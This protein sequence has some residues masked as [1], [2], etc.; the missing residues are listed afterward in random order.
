MVE[1]HFLKNL[2][3]FLKR[4]AGCERTDKAGEFQEEKR[5]PQSPEK[6]DW[7]DQFD[8]KIP[9]DEILRVHY[10]MVSLGVRPMALIGAIEAHP[11]KIQNLYSK[12]SCLAW[13]EG[14]GG[15]S[16][17]VRPIAFVIQEEEGVWARYGYAASGWIPETF[18]WLSDRVD[19][20]HCHRLIGLLLGYSVESIT[21]HDERRR[22]AIY[23]DTRTEIDKLPP[24]DPL[25]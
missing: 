12:L 13:E 22:G 1:I 6:Q 23:P 4:W 11:I 21:M 19:S 20:E 7:R 18:K 15:G 17:G 24:D 8:V 3:K 9:S 14:V 2:E 10:Y 25:L 5:L 16:P